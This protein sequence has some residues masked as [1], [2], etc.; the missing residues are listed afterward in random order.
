MG[1][2]LR[3]EG[4]EGEGWGGKRGEGGERKER[5]VF[6]LGFWRGSGG[7]GSETRASEQQRS[8]QWWWTRLG[9]LA[10]ASSLS[11]RKRG[12]R[13]ANTRFCPRSDCSHYEV[14][15]PTLLWCV[16]LPGSCD[17]LHEGQN[18]PWGSVVTN[19]ILMFLRI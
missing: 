6:L 11:R 1:S 13:P 2:D 12:S 10:L 16:L 18:L 8:L 5:C 3:G 7:G 9:W 19:R 17:C 4:I 15:S 14:G